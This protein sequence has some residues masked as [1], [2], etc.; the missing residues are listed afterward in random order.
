M[1]IVFLGD[2]LT[3]GGYGGNFVE[4]LRP[5]LPEHELINMGEGGNTV[6][7]LLRRLD[8]VL[9]LKPDAVFVM[10]GGNDAISFIQPGTRTY[11]R[12]AQ[13][14]EDGTVTIDQYE[15]GYR[16][17]LTQLQAAHIVTWMGLTPI[18]YN[19]LVVETMKQYNERAREV[20]RSMN[21]PTLDLL[22]ALN[23]PT[24]PERPNLEIGFILTIGSRQKR[25]WKDYEGDQKRGGFTYTF[26]GLHLMPE[27]AKRVAQLIAEFI[28]SN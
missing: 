8:E 6:L 5:L 12:N 16:E 2:S 11:Y 15:T 4:E 24:I 1:K 25:K 3:W 14:I 27:T 13:G 7:N 26:D 19:P 17:L 28:K 18:E 9:A 23:P 22:A 21:V 20:A 10:I